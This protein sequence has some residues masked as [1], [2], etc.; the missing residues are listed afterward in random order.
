[1]GKKIKRQLNNVK[2]SEINAPEERDPTGLRMRATR[3][4]PRNTSVSNKVAFVHPN[5]PPHPRRCNLSTRKLS[6]IVWILAKIAL[7]LKVT[8]QGL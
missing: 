1:M 4:P 5:P 3:Y 2:R 6:D 8:E 7:Y